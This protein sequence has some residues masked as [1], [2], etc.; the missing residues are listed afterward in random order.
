MAI[1]LSCLFFGFLVFNSIKIIPSG[2]EHAV[3]WWSSCDNVSC[4]HR[5]MMW[6]CDVKHGYFPYNHN[7]NQQDFFY[8]FPGKSIVTLLYS[9]NAHYIYTLFS[10]WFYVQEKTTLIDSPNAAFPLGK[11]ARQPSANPYYIWVNYNI[12]LTWI[13]AIWGWF[14]L[15][16]MISSEVAVRS[17]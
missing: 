17:L 1:S 14:P 5:E 13:E 6:N 11:Y 2:A 7:H 3:K 12:S 9:F 4:N 8:S 10:L 16:T 15:L